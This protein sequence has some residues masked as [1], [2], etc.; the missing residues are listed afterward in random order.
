MMNVEVAEVRA[1]TARN[2]RTPTHRRVATA[3]LL[4]V[5]APACGDVFDD[6]ANRVRGSGDVIV[7]TRPIDDFDRITLAGEGTVLVGRGTDGAV[8]IETDDNLLTHIRTNVS[9]DTLTISTESGL[10]ID[11]TDGVTYRLGCPDITSAE[12]TGAGTI[13]LAACTTTDELE[14]EVRGAGT[15][16]APELDLSTLQVSLPGAGSIDTTGRAAHLDVA[17]TGAGDFDGSELETD[18]AEVESV[19]IG[20]TTVW[21]TSDLDVS[22]TGVGTVRYYGEPAVS[23]TI[24]GVGTIEALGAK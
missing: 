7:E 15:I 22:V 13:D 1:S 17:L 23:S 20:T 10:D 5:L 21:V 3:A 4:C 6:G 2:P 16:T 9:G 11:P 19:G 24:T 8:E 18:T 14:L 12:L